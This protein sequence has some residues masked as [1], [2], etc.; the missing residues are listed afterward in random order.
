[1]KKNILLS[2]LFCA[3]LNNYA[4]HA[5]SVNM[6]NGSGTTCSST[7][8]DNGGS[9]S[10]YSNN[11]N[12]VYTFCPS[13]AG[14]YISVSFSAFSTENTYDYLY[15]YDG[16]TTSSTLLGAYTGTTIPSTI[17]ASNSAGCLTFKFTSDGASTSS[18][19]AATIS[20]SATAGTPAVN[21]SNGS[22]TTCSANFYD[23]GGNGLNYTNNQTLVYTFCPPTAGQYMSVTFSSFNI[24]NTYDFLYVY[25]GNSTAATLL[26][27]FT[28]TTNPGT[29]TA[30]SGNSTGCLT[31]RFTSDGVGNYSG[32]SAAISCSATPAPPSITMTNGSATT[33]SAA[34]YDNGGNSSNYSNNQTLVYTFCPSTAGQYMSVTFSSFNIEN[35]FDFLYIYDGASTSATLLGTY[36]GTTNPGTIT[37]TSGN[38]TGCLT[39]R[40]T[41]DGV[42]NYSGWN[43][44]IS[45][46]ATPAPPVITMANGSTSICSAAF[47]DNGGAS[48]NYSSNQSLTYTFCPSTPGQYV[49]AV[50]SSYNSE[51][52]YDILYIFDNNSASGTLLAALT[53]NITPGTYTATTANSTGCLTFR[54][55]SDGATTRAG[56]FATMSCSAAGAS[57]PASSSA[58]CNSAP[59][60]C[61]NTTFSGNSSGYGVQEIN[62]QNYGCLSVE[63]QSSWYFF[64]PSSSGTLGFTISPANGTDDYD[65]ALYGPFTT[66]TC[67]TSSNIAPLRCSWSDLSGN[68]GMGNGA[69]DTYED[70]LGNGWV[71]TI[72]V[73]AGQAYTLL[74]DNYSSSTSPFTLTWSLGGGASLDC[75]IILPIELLSFTGEAKE[76]KNILE[77]ITA[78][79]TNNNYFSIERSADGTNFQEIAR[80]TGAGT[81]V[82][83]R[84]Y[85]A[86]DL[87]PLEGANYYRLKQVDFDG[88]LSY[89]QVIAVEHYST[90]ISIDNIYPNPTTG[91]LNFNI[92][93]SSKGNVTIQVID[94]YGRTASKTK[95][96]MNEGHTSFTYDISELPK[97]IY[98]LKITSD[99]DNSST[100]SRIVKY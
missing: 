9:G 24:E 77:W 58:N 82:T 31:F 5:Q 72:N 14:Q 96:A 8:Y 46:S 51:S 98:T 47:Y 49:S 50:F 7:F 36:T 61:S 73:T 34:F 74:V 1:M 40:F 27:T 35:T 30:T 94:P 70:D 99:H 88:K 25:D 42:G 28:G 84:S 33:C 85:H 3:L 29:I 45:C 15:V 53:G 6:S 86:E 41:S 90:A 92:I 75:N 11:Q 37:A 17:T 68:T 66:G 2:L 48:S 62:F 80:V 26:G 18:G 63:H 81:S 39:F 76:K 13:T 16:S 56:W 93:S 23:N 12:L 64:S 89:S 67:P 4:L 100:V 71:S 83:D 57:P 78:T 38:S 44:I 97:G 10:N 43:A 32:W 22:T 20:C 69:S 65:F 19:W 95:A 21:M 54:F 52:G 55:I 59:T 79:E 87:S 60:I 91:E